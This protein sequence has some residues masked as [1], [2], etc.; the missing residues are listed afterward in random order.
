MDM[1]HKVLTAFREVN[2]RSFPEDLTR[3]IGN[4]IAP[5]IKSSVKFVVC[6]YDHIPLVPSAFVGKPAFIG[7]RKVERLPYPRMSIQ[8]GYEGEQEQD[9]FLVKESSDGLFFHVYTLVLLR[10]GA[11]AHPWAW[12]IKFNATEASPD[13]VQMG[14]AYCANG[15]TREEMGDL[16]QR[17]LEGI[18]RRFSRLNTILLLLTCKN[19]TTIEHKPDVALNKK[20]ARKGKPPLFT[21]HTLAIKPSVKREGKEPQDLWHNRIHLCRGHFKTYTE[22]A[23]LL[24]RLTGRYWWQPHVRGKNKDG[25]VMKDYS[26]NPED[27]RAQEG[28]L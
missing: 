11:A 19:I 24:G 25:I 8:I 10:T 28:R 16:T 20:R 14:V 13:Y 4:V 2:L 5:L 3:F 18:S 26:V 15:F 23:P 1:S 21:Y 17:E 12:K 22:D 9:F 27:F 7:D 6:D